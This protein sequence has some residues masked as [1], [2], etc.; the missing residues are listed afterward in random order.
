MKRVTGV[1]FVLPLVAALLRSAPAKKPEPTG[2]SPIKFFNSKCMY[3]HSADGAS[4]LPG[5][6]RAYSDERLLDRL[7]EMTDDKARSPLSNKELEVLASWFRSLGKQEPYIAWTALNDG[8]YTFE[9]T[10]GAT[11]TA[12]SGSMVL[13]RG[14]WTLRGVKDGETPT[15][16]ATKEKKKTVLKLAESAVSHPK[17]S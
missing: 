12:S 17:R 7:A 9:A 2:F 4:Y 16:T 14:K 6:L 8:V 5:S 11:L 15:V 3:C 1:L 10:K 13:D